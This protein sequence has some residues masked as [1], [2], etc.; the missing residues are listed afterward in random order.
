MVAGVKGVAFLDE[1]TMAATS[2][3]KGELFLVSK[4]GKRVVRCVALGEGVKAESLCAVPGTRS[5]LVA[6]A[7]GT[8]CRVD[9]GV[10]PPVVSCVATSAH[11]AGGSLRLTSVCA[12]DEDTCLVAG[13][14]RGDKASCSVR[15]VSLRS[16]E[17]AEAALLEAPMV[18]ALL[19]EPAKARA[20]AGAID[21]GGGGGGGGGEDDAGATDACTTRLVALPAADDFAAPPEV[22]ATVDFFVHAIAHHPRAGDDVYVLLARHG[23][24]KWEAPVRVVRLHE[25]GGHAPLVAL[26]SVHATLPISHAGL[27]KSLDYSILAA[28]VF[29]VRAG[30]E[31]A[32][33]LAPDGTLVTGCVDKASKGILQ[34]WNLDVTGLAAGTTP[35]SPDAPSS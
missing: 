13:A 32:M 23:G 3:T 27:V 16:G 11:H 7:K 5:V 4:S 12:W 9:L 6:D 2:S 34:L 26:Q 20:L 10:E 8:L 21:C 18:R 31:H 33:T 30:R 35:R 24:S 1:D 28:T 29:G 14:I 25:G 19:A 17:V 15:R 22:L